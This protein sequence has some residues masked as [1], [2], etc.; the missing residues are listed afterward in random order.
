MIATAVSIN[1]IPT[2]VEPCPVTAAA[3]AMTGQCH[4]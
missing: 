4:R 2:L 1:Q 3:S